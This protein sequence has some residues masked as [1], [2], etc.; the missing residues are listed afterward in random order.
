[1]LLY[2][3]IQTVALGFAIV[4]ITEIKEV[5]FMSKKEL[6]ENEINKISAGSDMGDAGN[7]VTGAIMLAGGVA[8]LGHTIKHAVKKKSWSGGHTIAATASALFAAASM[9]K[10][11]KVGKDEN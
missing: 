1:M 7:I 6:K 4:C 9:F 3:I 2:V 10:F 5:I 11:N 8:M